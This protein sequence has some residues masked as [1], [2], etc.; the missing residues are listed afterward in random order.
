MFGESRSP[1]PRP[2]APPGE[3]VG[4]GDETILEVCSGVGGWGCTE[5]G[6]GLQ[7]EGGAAVGKGTAVRVSGAT[8]SGTVGAQQWKCRPPFDMNIVDNYSLS[9]TVPLLY[10]SHCSPFALCETLEQCR[11]L[12][13]PFTGL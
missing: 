9:Y 3:R 7:W 12:S 11:A 1:V 4:P 13:R 8:M 5:K 2:R 10:S 6:V